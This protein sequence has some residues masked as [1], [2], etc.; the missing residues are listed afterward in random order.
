MAPARSSARRDNV[1]SVPQE[2]SGGDL[3]LDPMMGAPLQMYVD[4]DI[5]DRDF[6][7]SLINVRVPLVRVAH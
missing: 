2:V 4:K 5:N 1:Q 7:V 6:L 3:F